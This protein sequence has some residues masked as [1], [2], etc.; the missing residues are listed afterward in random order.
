MD[1]RADHD[2]ALADVAERGRDELSGRREHDHRVELLRRARERVAGPGGSEGAG[3]RLSLGVVRASAGEDPAALGDGDLADDVRRGAE[4]V[5]ADA[6]AVA[7]EPERAVA[8]EPRA[9]QRR[10]LLVRIAGGN[11]EAVALVGD[12]ELRV[13]AVEVVAGEAGA[14]AEVLAPCEAEPALAARP[15]EPRDADP[16]A[17]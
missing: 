17:G 15:P 8:D 10:S 6:L 13:A 11:R 4:A 16:V 7:G 3:E 14:V 9:E 2:A 5:E 1:A 12:G